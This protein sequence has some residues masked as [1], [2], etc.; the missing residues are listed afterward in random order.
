MRLS[1]ALAA[2]LALPAFAGFKDG[3]YTSA[4]HGVRFKAPADWKFKEEAHDDGRFAM[5][6]SED[7]KGTIV[8]RKDGKSAKDY[9]KWRAEEWGKKFSAVTWDSEEKLDGRTPGEW[10]KVVL[11]LEDGD[12]EFKSVHVIVANGKDDIELVLFCDEKKYESLG[13]VLDGVVASLE[14]GEFKEEPA[15]DPVKPPDD[16]T[17]PPANPPDDGTKKPVTPPDD[18]AKPATG[19]T[20][21]DADRGVGL[22]GAP[23]WTVHTSDFKM[24]DKYLMAEWDTGHEKV[25]FGFSEAPNDEGLDA[26]SWADTVMNEIGKSFENL[27][28]LEGTAPAGTERRDFTAESEGK[29]IRFVY[30]F[31]LRGKKAYYIQSILAADQWDTYK[32]EI[33]GAIA[34][35]AQ[36]D[37]AAL[38]E[39]MKA[40][41]EKK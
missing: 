14:L 36:G 39:D 22:R 28:Q 24:T 25:F 27:T 1:L 5:W 4:A 33:D 26:K 3:V 34:T 16:G 9:M 32:A 30:V 41:Q 31:F 35:L 8:H 23:G 7:V 29:G 37:V 21:A 18:G 19:P 2:L 6:E 15:D 38:V 17:K 13:K 20:W 11:S 10:R 12:A 40:P